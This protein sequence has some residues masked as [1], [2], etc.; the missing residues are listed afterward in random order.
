MEYRNDGQPD[1]ETD[2]SSISISRVSVLRRDK[3][4]KCVVRNMNNRTSER[5]DRDRTSLAD[6]LYC[7]PLL[8]LLLLL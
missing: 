1:G 7:A 3:N 8:L 5:V 6:G 4:G 2:R